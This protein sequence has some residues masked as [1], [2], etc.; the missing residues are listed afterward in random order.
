MLVNYSL[1]FETP[2]KP[3]NLTRLVNSLSVIPFDGSIGYTRIASNF[4]ISI[5]FIK[6]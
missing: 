2:S 5:S 3:K 4:L 6:F 1:A